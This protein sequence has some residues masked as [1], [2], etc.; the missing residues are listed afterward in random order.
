ML[1]LQGNKTHPKPTSGYVLSHTLIPPSFQPKVSTAAPGVVHRNMEGLSSCQ[2]RC[3]HTSFWRRQILA[4]TLISYFFCFPR[5]VFPPPPP[6]PFTQCKVEYC[7]FA[8][9]TLKN[10]QDLQ[11]VRQGRSSLLLLVLF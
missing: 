11:K 7:I 9:Q 1:G 6:P 5:I 8:L 3:P 4:D 10:Q 2:Q